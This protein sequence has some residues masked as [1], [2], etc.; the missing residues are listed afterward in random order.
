MG[1]YIVHRTKP[2]PQF[3]S[4]KIPQGLKTII[5][6]NTIEPTTLEAM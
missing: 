1:K 3:S 6:F 2:E 5:N 4:H